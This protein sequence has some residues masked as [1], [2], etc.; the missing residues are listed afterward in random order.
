MHTIIMSQNLNLNGKIYKLNRKT[1]FARCYDCYN[2]AKRIYKRNSKKHFV[3]IG[4]TCEKCNKVVLDK[5]IVI[6]GK[7]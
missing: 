2:L 1:K 3:G 5:D 7:L 6:A 4:Y